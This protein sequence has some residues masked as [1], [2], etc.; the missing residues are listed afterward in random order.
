MSIVFGAG[1]PVNT[2]V[3]E[4]TV[5]LLACYGCGLV[6]QLMRTPLRLRFRFLNEH[7]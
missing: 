4:L 7:S 2:L 1:L 3:E 6:Q 5:C